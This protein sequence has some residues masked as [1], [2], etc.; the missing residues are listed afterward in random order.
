MITQY[1]SLPFTVPIAGGFSTNIVGL[2]G[3]PGEYKG[4]KWGMESNIPSDKNEEWHFNEE[5]WEK[6]E[7]LVYNFVDSS[8]GQSGSPIF[9][10]EF[11]CILGVHTGGSASLKKN[12]GTYITPTKLRWIANTL[13]SPWRIIYDYSTLYLHYK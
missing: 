5:D 11:N 8:P 2:V 3:F 12:W 9:G 6:K 4:E 1:D 7:I 10:G 13:G